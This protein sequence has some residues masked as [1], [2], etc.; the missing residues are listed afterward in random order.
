MVPIR[1]LRNGGFKGT[2]RKMPER[3]VGSKFNARRRRVIRSTATLLFTAVVLCLFVIWGRDRSTSAA[4]LKSVDPAVNDLR[5]RMRTLGALPA[6]LPELGI[7]LPYASNAERFYAMNSKDP[8]II[9][10]TSPVNLL[11]RQNGRAVI[12]YQ[13]G[14]I[15]SEWLSEGEF[16]KRLQAQQKSMEAFEA[17]VRSRPPELP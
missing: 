7:K 16:L 15:W 8:V 17:S 11:L 3:A 10:Y 9:A 14:K 2:I 4:V 5:Q 12:V 1:L 13:N 6:S